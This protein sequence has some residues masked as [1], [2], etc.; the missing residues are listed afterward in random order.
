[1]ESH[2]SRC[3]RLN[4]QRLFGNAPAEI[5]WGGSFGYDLQTIQAIVNPV[6]R[7]RGRFWCLAVIKRLFSW[8]G[9]EVLEEGAVRRE[10]RLL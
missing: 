8:G 4:T 2:I 5:D 10:F 3:L 7:I 1:M 6:R 9:G